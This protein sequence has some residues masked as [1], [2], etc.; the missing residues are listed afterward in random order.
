MNSPL[1]ISKI[2]T[3]ISFIIGTLILVLF[4]F[5]KQHENLIMVGLY[6]IIIAF[7]INSFIFLF[8]LSKLIIDSENNTDLLKALGIILLN[9]PIT[10][11]YF[12]IVI[13]TI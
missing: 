1:N 2:A 10:F 13:K 11:G 4:L 9:L 6:Y 7:A 5:N 8:L 3:G 12:F